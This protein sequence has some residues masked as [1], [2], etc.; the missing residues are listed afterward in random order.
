MQ[1]DE[2]NGSNLIEMMH[3]EA[4]M[5]Q[6]AAKSFPRKIINDIGVANLLKQVQNGVAAQQHHNLHHKMPSPTSIHSISPARS[7]SPNQ[8]LMTPVAPS[9]SSILDPSK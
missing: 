9:T 3:D 1:N 7:A 6:L 2:V 8:L 4:L 5:E